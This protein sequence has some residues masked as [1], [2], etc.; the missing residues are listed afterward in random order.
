MTVNLKK[1]PDPI[2]ITDREPFLRT[3]HSFLKEDKLAVDTEANSLHAYQEQVCLIQLST[4]EKD[5][6]VDPFALDDLSALGEVFFDPAVEKIFHA[7]EYDLNILYDDFG[8]EFQNLFDT[9]LA[10]RILGR[11][12]LGLDSLLEEFA[13]V[14]S[15][16]KYQRADWGQRPLTG[17]M[18]RYA[19]KDTHYLI[20]IRNALAEELRDS[21]RWAIAQEDFSLACKVHTRPKKEKLPPCWRIHGSQDLSPQEAAILEE[22]CA[23]RDRVARQKD[24]PLFKILGNKTLLALAE[25]APKSKQTFESLPVTQN[26]NVKRYK[27]ALWK[28]IQKGWE[29]SPL[30]P[31]E[32]ERPDRDTLDRLHALKNW[33]KKK[34]REVGLNSAVILPRFLVAE[35]AKKNPKTRAEL[36]EILSD[37]PLRFEHYWKELL[38]VLSHY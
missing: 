5:Y 7:S 24:Q 18:L 1:L 17:D 19:Q 36:G 28:A 11:K 26:T 27:E 31:P 13:G 33:R 15:N 25:S 38:A 14:Q 23:F 6:I 34:A 30:L 35:I 4:V 8:F 20:K 16:K 21:G 12:K 32:R 37:V 29:A 10:A 3:I 22:L 2:F 9:M